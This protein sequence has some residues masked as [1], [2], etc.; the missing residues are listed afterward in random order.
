MATGDKTTAVDRRTFLVRAGSTSL[1][2]LAFLVTGPAMG[3]RPDYPGGF[4]RGLTPGFAVAPIGDEHEIIATMVDTILPGK[5]TDPDGSPGA[6]EAGALNLM[7]D[8]FY[9]A[10]PYVPTIVQMLESLSQDNHGV[11]FVELSQD[12]REEVLLSAQEIVP[13]LRH[14]YRFV[15]SVY[16]A[17]LHDGTG[18]HE[19]DF[20][21]PNLGYIDHP[22]FSFRKPM[23]QEATDDGNMP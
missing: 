2:S 11:P 8:S 3:A 20:P 23:S 19:L 12:E 15:R 10:R 1:G 9:P 16:Y 4:T 6:L 7:Y 22:E 14:A 5:A 13:F 17:G 21:G 18:L